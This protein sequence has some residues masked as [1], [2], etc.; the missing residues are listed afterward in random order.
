MEFFNMNKIIVILV[1]MTL[2]SS[3]HKKDEIPV[4]D[5]SNSGW[6]YQPIDTS[7]YAFFFKAGSYWVYT[8]DTT[9]EK[10][11]V[12]LTSVQTGCEPCLI[13]PADYNQGRNYQYYIMNYLSKLTNEAGRHESWLYDCLEGN[14]LMRDHHPGYYDWYLGWTLYGGG[15]NTIDSLRVGSNTFYKLYYSSDR[16]TSPT[17]AYTAKGIGIVKK[18]INGKEFDLVRWKIVK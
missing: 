12:Y 13:P 16:N 8:N 5:C 10:D 7:M 3:C 11:S 4:F 1:G 6:E 9:K 18:I 15:L 17:Y 2:L 14:S